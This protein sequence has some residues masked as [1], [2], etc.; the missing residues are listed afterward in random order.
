VP[1][2][3]EEVDL[4]VAVPGVARALLLVDLLGRA[5]DLVPVLGLAGALATPGVVLDVRLLPLRS[6][7]LISPPS[8]SRSITIVPTGSPCML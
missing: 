1:A 3:L 6:A 2:A 7:A 8:A 5:L 4:A